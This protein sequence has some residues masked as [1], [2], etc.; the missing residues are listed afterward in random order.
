MSVVPPPNNRH[1]VYK[2]VDGGGAHFSTV[3]DSFEKL[4]S[5]PSNRLSANMNSDN[6]LDYPVHRCVDKDAANYYKKNKL[7]NAGKYTFDCDRESIVGSHHE[8]PTVGILPPPAHSR[9]HSQ[10]WMAPRIYYPFHPHSHSEHNRDSFSFEPPS[11]HHGH[12]PSVDGS[13][14]KIGH[15]GVNSVLHQSGYREPDLLEVGTFPRKR[16]NQRFRVPSNQSVT[17]KVTI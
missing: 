1:S 3:G 15:L 13:G 4:R 17:S 7:G 6:S 16:E 2:S 11:F 5:L 14:R 8:P 12:S 10:L 9:I